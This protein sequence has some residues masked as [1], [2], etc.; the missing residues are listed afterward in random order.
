MSLEFLKEKI[1]WYKLLFTLL[2]TVSVGNVSWFIA[3]YKTSPKTIIAIDLLLI[4]IMFTGL[5][6]MIYKVRFYLKKLEE[7]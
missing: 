7:K 2:S 1:G 4:P 3:S 6:I 5:G